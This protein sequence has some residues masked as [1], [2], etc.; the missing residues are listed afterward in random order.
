MHIQLNYYH[1]NHALYGLAICRELYCTCTTIDVDLCTSGHGK[2][3][4]VSVLAE[5]AER[6]QVDDIK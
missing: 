3:Q 5:R 4:R 6:V 2:L 1:A